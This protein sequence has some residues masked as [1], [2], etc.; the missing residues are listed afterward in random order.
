MFKKLFPA[1]SHC[2]ALV[3]LLVLTLGRMAAPAGATEYDM[4][5]YLLPEADLTAAIGSGDQAL[6]SRMLA[7]A[8]YIDSMVLDQRFQ[9]GSWRDAVGQ[10]VA[11]QP[12]PDEFA[13]GFAVE[14]LLRDLVPEPA[15]F[16][17]P[18]PF[19]S[20]VEPGFTAAAAQKP[21][22]S[23]FLL[24]LYRGVGGSGTALDRAIGVSEYPAEIWPVRPDDAARI[25]DELPTVP[26]IAGKLEAFAMGDEGEEAAQGRALVAAAARMQAEFYGK[27]EAEITEEVEMNLRDPYYF[28]EPMQFLLEEYDTI[29]AA[30]TRARDEGKMAVFV[31]HSW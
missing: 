20:M 23:D 29:G 22:L 7:D 15:R 26:A 3:F 13:N 27:S 18:L 14:L 21:A 12:R 2:C 24:G 8:E 16:Q 28:V 1:V 19:A 30:L 10:L 25:L 11:G 4:T 31:Y 5:I 9:D 17:I 6:Q